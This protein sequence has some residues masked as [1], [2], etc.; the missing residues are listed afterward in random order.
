VEAHQRT[1][2]YQHQ[3]HQC[4]VLDR[5]LTPLHATHRMDVIATCA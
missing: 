5:R 3:Q 4:Q 2:G 1:R